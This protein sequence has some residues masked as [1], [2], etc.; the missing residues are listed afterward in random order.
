MFLLIRFVCKNSVDIFIINVTKQSLQISNLTSL[1]NGNKFKM[2]IPVNDVCVSLQ[3]DFDLGTRLNWAQILNDENLSSESEPMSMETVRHVSRIPIKSADRVK[4]NSAGSQKSQANRSVDFRMY[5]DDPDELRDELRRKYMMTSSPKELD[6]HPL[7]TTPESAMITDEELKKQILTKA[8]APFDSPSSKQFFSERFQKQ[9][10]PSVKN[11]EKASEKKEPTPIRNHMYFSKSEPS[12]FLKADNNNERIS[13]SLTTTVG[14]PEQIEHCE[15]F[16]GEGNINEQLHGNGQDL[17]DPHIFVEFMKQK[18]TEMSLNSIRDMLNQLQNPNSE[19][20]KDESTGKKNPVC[21]S[22]EPKTSFPPDSSQSQFSIAR[23]CAINE[24]RTAM[25]E[26][27][28]QHSEIQKSDQPEEYRT[29]N[30]SYSSPRQRE[31][32]R[33]PITCPISA[34]LCSSVFVSEFAKHI[35]VNHVRV[36][37]EILQ[38]GQGTNVFVDITLDELNENRCRMLY[39]VEGKIAQLGSSRYRNYLPIMLMSARISM[40]QILH[41]NGRCEADDVDAVYDQCTLVWLT[42]LHPSETECVHCTLSAWHRSDNVP[43]EHL[44]HSGR[45]YSIRSGQQAADVYHSGNGMVLT[46][47]QLAS[48]TDGGKNH[49]KMQVVVH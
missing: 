36:P 5:S 8:L 38:P 49:M 4:P 34:C 24:N 43:T 27:E 22:N 20:R 2:R 10:E 46:G 1:T 17:T 28:Q 12:S 35:R 16:R 9:S 42:G 6:P 47:Q 44:V 32:S 41:R 21:S 25:N 37:A 15:Q 26:P 45:M 29:S 39:L 33:R 31:L 19:T 14:Q 18:F 11:V 40:R 30:K 13:Q 3:T 7:C 48:L 23:R